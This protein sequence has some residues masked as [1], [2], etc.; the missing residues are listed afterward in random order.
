MNERRLIRSIP[1]QGHLYETEFAK[2]LGH[3]SNVLCDELKLYANNGQVRENKGKYYASIKSSLTS[4]KTLLAKNLKLI[5]VASDLRETVTTPTSS[6]TDSLPLQLSSKQREYIKNYFAKVASGV[7]VKD[8]KELYM[9][10]FVG[11]T[12][13]IDDR[14]YLTNLCSEIRGDIEKCGFI[15]SLF[16]DLTHKFKQ[17]LSSQHTSH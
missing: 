17:L 8:I 15:L 7:K 1:P 5:R 2:S 11:D 12:E 16:S 14:K 10:R 9:V 4:I 6:S 13:G 3:S